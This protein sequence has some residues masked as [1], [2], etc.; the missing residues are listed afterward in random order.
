MQLEQLR[1]FL[2]VVEH[3]S[4]TRAARSRAV[5]QSTIST[6]IAHLETSVGT[7]LL[8]RDRSGVRLTH[9]GTRLVPRARRLLALADETLTA[10]AGPERQDQ[11]TLA[12]STIPATFLLPAALGRLRAAAPLLTLTMDVSDSTRALRS[13]LDGTIDIAVIGSAPKDPRLLTHPIGDDRIVLV[14]PRGRELP[15][16]LLTAPLVVREPGSGTAQAV[17]HLLPTDNPRIQVSSTEAVRRCVLAGLGFALVSELAIR[18]DVEA[19]RLVTH[20][21]EGTPLRRSFHVARLRNR[22]PGPWT[23]RLWADLVGP[24]LPPSTH[25]DPHGAGG[26]SALHGSPG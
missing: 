24:S 26:E 19:G 1:T 9:A 13:L 15:T 14:G 8:D 7:R 4:F 12:A 3:G 10:V 17:A 2:H 5:S 21:F 11:L 22:T 6:H 25:R 18:D 20:P 16:D 23:R